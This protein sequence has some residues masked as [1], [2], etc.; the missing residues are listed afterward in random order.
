LKYWYYEADFS[1][2]SEK[3]A[4]KQKNIGTSVQKVP[5]LMTQVVL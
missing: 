4:K 1:K 3:C 5:R 2:V